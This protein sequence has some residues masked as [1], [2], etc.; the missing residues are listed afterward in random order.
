MCN[1]RKLRKASFVSVYVKPF[2]ITKK[3]WRTFV[4]EFLYFP[5]A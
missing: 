1:D 5:D 2:C 3:K 4:Y